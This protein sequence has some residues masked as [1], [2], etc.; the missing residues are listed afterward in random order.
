MKGRKIPDVISEEEFLKIIKSIKKLKLKT[1]FM[2]GFYQCLR[3]SE[4][5][6]L[7]KKNI[8]TKKGFVHVK[9]GKGNK[10]RDIPLVP[11]VLHYLRYLPI[12]MSRQGLHKAI[13][14]KAKNILNKEI[15]FHT[16]RHSGASMYL[17]ERH[18]D[19]RFIQQF[20]GHSNLSTTQI[21][22]HVNPTQLKS[23]FENTSKP[24]QM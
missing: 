9:A 13:K 6:N 10:D 7:E 2:L 8:D 15:H 21:Y 1:A 12:K 11:E 17:N 14:V 5:I 4:V 18:I 19:L 3:V 23:A 24:N 20:L 22:L 16:L